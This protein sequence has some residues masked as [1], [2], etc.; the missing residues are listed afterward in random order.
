MVIFLTLLAALSS[1]HVSYAAYDPFLPIN[2]K[3]PDNSVKA[4]FIPFGATLTNFWTKDRTGKFRDVLLGFDN[5]ELYSN[6][7]DHPYAGAIVGRYANRIKNAT[8]SIP[9]SEYP[10]PGAPNTYEVSKNIVSEGIFL[11]GGFIGYDRFNWTI[12][13]QTSSSV[14]LYHFDPP[15]HE[16]FPGSVK[17]WVTYT[18]KSGGIWDTYIKALASEKTPIM[19]TSHAYWNLDAWQ[20]SEDI[21]DHYLQIN[22]SKVVALASDGHPTG[23]IWDVTGTALD[24]RTPTTVGARIDDSST[25]TAP[26]VHGYDYDWIYDP[27][28]S[29]QFY[30]KKSG[31]KFEAKTNQPCV[32]IYTCQGFNLPRKAAH[33]G[34]TK[35]YGNR[36]CAAIEQQSYVDAIHHPSWG[37]DQIY[38]PGRDYVWTSSYKFSVIP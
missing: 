35:V 34:P 14:T 20:E 36:G 30:S 19:L 32:Q 27:K 28:P 22:S 21:L 37:V 6:G 17:V 23:D 25:S 1:L 15:G 13:S 8:F 5:K 33:G 38:H 11:H 10:I 29:F 3:A 24:F 18:L 31:I 26:G 7:P 4:T 9:P 16:G 2:L 12:T